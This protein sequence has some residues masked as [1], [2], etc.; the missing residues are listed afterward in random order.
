MYTSVTTLGPFRQLPVSEAHDANPTWHIY[1]E[2]FFEITDLVFFSFFLLL[3]S[4]SPSNTNICTNQISFKHKF[5][6]EYERLGPAS[7][8]VHTILHLHNCSFSV[9]KIIFVPRRKPPDLVLLLLFRHSLS[10]S[11]PLISSSTPTTVLYSHLK[12]NQI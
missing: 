6:F 10:L 11:L 4:F 9:K 2:F 5:K 12:Q 7:F 3:S 1:K 8:T